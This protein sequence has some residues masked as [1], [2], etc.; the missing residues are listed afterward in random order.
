MPNTERI[1]SLISPE[2][3]KQFE[4]LKASTDANTASFEKLIAKAVEL[5]KAVGNASTFKEVNKATAEMTANE[6]A[7]AKQVD[8]LAKANEKLTKLFDQQ[9]KKLQELSDKKKKDS[10]DSKKNI[11]AVAKA[12]EKLIN[13]YSAEARK[14][15]EIREQQALVNKANK[16]S[17][18]ETLGLSG[19]YKQLEQQYKKAAQENNK[20]WSIRQI[21]N[22]PKKRWVY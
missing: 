13:S 21:N 10:D 18:Q 14:L 3:L 19:A 5:N 6:K 22:Q 12:E 16:Q 9:A 7:L 8:E 1:E 4:Q 17:A 20:R 15:A 2:A 11:D